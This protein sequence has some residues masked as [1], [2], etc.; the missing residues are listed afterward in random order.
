MTDASHVLPERCAV[1][2]ALDGQ[3]FIQDATTLALDLAGFTAL[4]E[5]LSA[6]GTRGTEQLSSA[7]RGYFAQVAALVAEAGGDPVAFGGDSLTVVYD[8]P[9]GP[10]LDA[11]IAS[12]RRIQRLRTRTSSE[13][14]S[15]IPS[16]RLGVAHGTVATGLAAHGGRL[17][18]VHV[19]PGLDLAHAAQ[20]R[21]EPGGIAVHES[22]AASR[23]GVRTAP[24]AAAVSPTPGS[25]PRRPGRGEAAASGPDAGLLLN[26][27][28][29]DRLRRGEAAAQSHRVVT[30]AFVRFPPVVPHD[31]GSFLPVVAALM[32]GVG[33]A[34]GEVV[35][36]SGGDKGVLA[37]VVLGAPTAHQDDP[38]R[39]VH[40]MVEL[41]RQQPEVAVGV[42]TGPVFTAVL[43]SGERVF[44]THS[45]VAVNLAARLSQQAVT[46][47]LLVDG[48][49]WDAS[50]RHLRQAAAP[51]LAEI[52][53]VAAPVRVHG[54]EGWRHSSPR[55]R[56]A[57][58]LELVGRARERDALERLLEE[59]AA[60]RGTSLML[61]GEPGVG[62]TRLVLE[63][64]DRA[65]TRGFLVVDSDAAD[66]PR[67]ANGME[68]R[69]ALVR[70]LL[71]VPR[72]APRRALARALAE[73]LR[74]VE[75]QRVVLTR[76]L[77]LGT[78]DGPD[79]ST[80]TLSAEVAGGLAQTALTRLVQ[81]ATLHRP[82]LLVVES[83]DRLDPASLI[84]VHGLVSAAAGCTAASL[85][86]RGEPESGAVQPE[87]ARL[88]ADVPALTLGPLEPENVGLVAAD[89]WRLTGGGSPPPWL[90][91]A[92]VPRAGGNPLLATLVTREL[93]ATWQ[94]GN[95]P[96]TGD[97]GA[98]SATSLLLGQVDRLAADERALLTALAVA[99][100]PCELRLITRLLGPFADPAVV[101]RAATHLME[102]GFIAGSDGGP[103]ERYRL[104]HDLLRQVV[105]D[106]TSHAERDRLHRRLVVLLDETDADPV[107]VA[108]HVAHVEDD[109][110][111]RRWFPRAARAARDSWDLG[112]AQ[113]WL[114]ALRPLASGAAR[115]LVELE[116]LEVLLVAGRAQEVL[117]RLDGVGSQTPVA[118][119]RAEEV[120]DPLPAARRM[121]AL[122]EATYS[123]GQLP[124]TE[125]AAA[126]AMQL[127][128]GVDES[129]YQRAGELLTL[130]RCHQGDVEGALGAGRALVDRAGRRFDA[131]AR[132]NALA[133]LAVALVLSGR[134]ADAAECY[135]A[136]LS[137]AVEAGD[138]V[139]E[140]HV[141]SDLAGCA[142]MTGNHARCIELL[143]RAR[144]RADEIGY[145]RHL[146]LNLSNEAQL[147]VALG[148]PF[149]TVC[150]RLAVERSLYLG[151]L[152]TAADALHTW[153]TATPEL[154]ADAT[155]WRRLAGVDEALDRFLEAALAWAELAVVLAR[156][157]RAEGARDAVRRA[158]D[159]ARGEVTD[160]VRN[161]LELARVLTEAHQ[162]ASDRAPGRAAAVK[163]LGRLA[164]E[165]TD[166]LG[167][168]LGGRDAAELALDR[169][170][171]SRSGADRRVAASLSLVAME[172]E[173]SAVV[174][175]WLQELGEPVPEAPDALPA[176]VGVPRSRTTRRDLDEAFSAVELVIAGRSGGSDRP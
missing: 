28:L 151:D 171:L 114:E 7:L 90:A 157:G 112:G 156:S 143:T 37:M 22:A 63:A 125:A 170:R 62:K 32:E 87:L 97:V 135:E 2:G 142:Y 42:A 108:E 6:R 59:A 56:R 169:W 133:A 74:E 102:E 8:G 15:G 69:R 54:I 172:E 148:D 80:D 119:D 16:A 94:P 123:C 107:S 153:V 174:R 65:Q 11:A 152:G 103:E 84:L 137:A 106:D 38:A 162:A 95:P 61:T 18:P 128:D 104:T 70:Q 138:V 140:V 57:A 19:G 149:A 145:R 55:P 31:L 23:S 121:L 58:R 120:L 134:P 146:A 66:H 164:D 40:A 154:A 150:A 116:L 67:L 43:R 118:G 33:D 64:I 99:R 166:E 158:E 155:L 81:R 127:Y 141:V 46:G 96:P 131:A 132:S 29:L 117:D 93:C 163:A 176:P 4:T 21:A 44:A 89:L 72:D 49:T 144:Q 12:A 3:V 124:R 115:E 73:A 101:P 68:L 91:G 41:R 36:V 139:R 76:L 161:R 13:L 160:R 47:E 17:L 86:T 92:V 30:V 110:L 98:G 5:R 109:E 50:A 25:G 136:A 20:E 27:A 82:L 100:R 126:Q 122:A 75:G 77:G 53:G 1:P 167:D 34:G 45:G 88:L 175:S 105:Y 159:C 78:S 173:P 9:P 129:R 48:L 168:G 147:R 10:T 26:P 35:Q 83:V 130:A 51:R 85:L 14:D 79:S 111:A 60:G 71:D 39:A 52:K 113:R 24:V 165:L